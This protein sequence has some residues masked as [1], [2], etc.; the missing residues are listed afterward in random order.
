MGESL[1]Q[2][3]DLKEK[4]KKANGCKLLNLEKIMTKAKVIVPSNFVPADAVIREGQAL[5][6]MIG[7]KGH[8]GGSEKRV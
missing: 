6:E 1:I 4:T 2:P 3:H 5:F 8:V 7:R